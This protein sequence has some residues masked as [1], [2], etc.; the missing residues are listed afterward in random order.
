MPLFSSLL[1]PRAGSLTP[2]LRRYGNP[3]IESDWAFLQHNSPYQRLDAHCFG[4]DAWRAPPTL[5]TT[6]TKDDRVHPCH[7]RKMV[8]KLMD[9]PKTA[10]TVRYWENLEGGHGGAAGNEQRAYMWA[11]TYRLLFATVGRA[12]G[13]GRWSAGVEGVEEA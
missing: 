7:A 10:G 3:D 2:P 12:A 8:K 11:V 1:S 6:S 4:N 5:F 9:C 13:L